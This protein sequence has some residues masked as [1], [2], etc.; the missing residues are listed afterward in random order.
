M[1]TPR[2]PS[3]RK[4]HTKTPAKLP[5][6][7]GVQPEPL[8]GVSDAEVPAAVDYLLARLAAVQRGLEELYALTQQ[9]SAAIM[10][11]APNTRVDMLE[12]A[13][14]GLTERIRELE[15]MPHNRWRPDPA[16]ID[17]TCPHCHGTGRK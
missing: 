2:M 14:V 17:A 8:R 16:P 3:G 1:R 7:P 11:L 10:G 5:D 4:G 6:K 13:V 12:R 9:Q 15:A